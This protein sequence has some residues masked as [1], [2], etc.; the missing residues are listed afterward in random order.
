[1]ISPYSTRAVT[2]IKKLR[3]LNK[4][5]VIRVKYRFR[6]VLLI[7]RCKDNGGKWQL[8]C[9]VS[10]QIFILIPHDHMTHDLASSEKSVFK[11]LKIG[12]FLCLYDQGGDMIEQ[13]VGFY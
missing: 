8:F 5:E 6:T 4:Y 11:V 3:E 10:W 2:R 9:N 1:M 12:E 13:L 7:F